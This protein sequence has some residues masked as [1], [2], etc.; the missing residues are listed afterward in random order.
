M[1]LL[2]HIFV[3]HFGMKV[4]ALLIAVT[5]WVA[6]T[7][8]PVVETG[9]SAPLLLINM[10]PDLQVSGEIPSS[11]LVRL[12][13]RLGRMRRMDAA[14]LTVSADCGQAREGIQSVSLLPNIATGPNGPE[15]VSITPSQI[16]I[17]LVSGSARTGAP[18]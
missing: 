8:E 18:R 1:R 2:H 6:Y 15:I 17:S 11:V 14:G 9:Y 4:G 13:G 12:R 16:E 7:S 10:P 3:S 5:L